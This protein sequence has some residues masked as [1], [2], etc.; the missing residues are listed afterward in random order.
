MVFSVVALLSAILRTRAQKNSSVE[1]GLQLIRACAAAFPVSTRFPTLSFMLRANEG[2]TAGKR[3]ALAG[4]LLC[5]NA[6]WVFAFSTQM[7]LASDDD[8]GAFGLPRA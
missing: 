3:P 2:E 1:S 8:Y 6:L 4:R 5:G 7:P